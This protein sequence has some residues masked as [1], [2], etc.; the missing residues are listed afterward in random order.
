MKPKQNLHTNEQLDA[1]VTVSK[2]T[3]RKPSLVELDLEK[4]ETGTNNL[5]NDDIII[6]RAS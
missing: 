3:W 1:Q 4:T 6:M 2:K 5:A